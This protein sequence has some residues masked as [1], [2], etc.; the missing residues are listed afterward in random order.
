L[1]K[2]NGYWG[3]CDEVKG[4]YNFKSAVKLDAS[5]REVPKKPAVPKQASPLP[6][7]EDE[8]ASDTKPPKGGKLKYDKTLGKKVLKWKVDG[9]WLNLKD[10]LAYI[11]S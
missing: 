11:A 5:C 3:K 10:F 9:N 2:Y 4:S 6:K 7:S 8:K 1:Y